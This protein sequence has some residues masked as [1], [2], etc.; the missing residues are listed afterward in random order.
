MHYW[1]LS[2][3]TSV[4]YV[5]LAVTDLVTQLYDTGEKLYYDVF[6]ENEKKN[7]FMIT[8]GVQC[9]SST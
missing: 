2:I 1:W 6:K 9:C 8:S 5:F 7:T 3:Q 4:I